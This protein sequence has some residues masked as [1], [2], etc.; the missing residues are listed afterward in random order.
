MPAS[1]GFLSHSWQMIHP[2]G[3]NYFLNRWTTDE[4]QPYHRHKY[5]EGD[6]FFLNWPDSRLNL[7]CRF[8][9]IMTSKWVPL[10]AMPWNHNHLHKL[11]YWIIR[12][13][14]QF[15]SWLPLLPQKISA[16]HLTR[17]GKPQR[18]NGHKRRLPPRGTKL[19]LISWS[20]GQLTLLSHLSI[21]F[22]T[23]NKQMSMQHN[24]PFLWWCKFV[25][26]PFHNEGKNNSFA[27]NVSF[28]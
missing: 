13:S 11:G 6:L 10:L 18:H 25:K 16:T 20:V 2:A 21:R 19:G 9:R 26:S 24:H 7:L 22:S 27:L 28:K 15:R 23:Y 4:Q 1:V 8:T 14:N 5:A 17:L 3:C 12:W